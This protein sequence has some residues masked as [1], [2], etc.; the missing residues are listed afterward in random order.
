MEMSTTLN[1]LNKNNNMPVPGR[2]TQFHV[3]MGIYG[4]RKGLML[5]NLTCT[6]NCL[7]KLGVMA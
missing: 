4:I 5:L 1:L 3:G 2:P 7:D 6:F